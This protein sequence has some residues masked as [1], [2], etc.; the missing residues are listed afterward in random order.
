MQGLDPVTV[1]FALLAIF[2]VWKLKS[3][4]GQRV[5]I[6][7]APPRAAARAGSGPLPGAAP[8]RPAVAPKPEDFARFADADQVRQGLADIAAADRS[9]DAA[10]FVAGAG[11]AYE[12]I[13]TAFAKGDR[14]TLTNLLSPEVFDSFA[15][16]LDARAKA[17]ETAE[18]RFVGLDSTRI[19][20]ASLKDGVAHIGVRIAAKMIACVR[21]ASGAV[22]SGDPQKVVD[23]D[24][25][26]AF[27]R[28]IASPDPNWKLVATQAA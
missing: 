28:P 26:W 24:D 10:K 1:I 6:D 12:M 23:A 20:E 17:G 2:V 21:D 13:V 19:V 4:L 8:L 14:K 27:A 18:T 5:E 3:V 7:R 25:V 11:S 15:H 22:I 16:V 9:F